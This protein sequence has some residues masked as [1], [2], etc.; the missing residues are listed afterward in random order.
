[1]ADDYS[2]GSASGS[3]DRSVTP[4]QG[5]IGETQNSGGRE[6]WLSPEEEAPLAGAIREFPGYLATAEDGDIGTILRAFDREGG[7]LVVATDDG[8]R[9]VPASAVARVDHG[10]RTVALRIRRGRVGDLPRWDDNAS[11]DQV[12]PGVVYAAALVLLND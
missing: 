9:I 8:A 1:M 6:Q 4:R 10:G 3:S 2:K 12:T 5:A 7:V 11:E